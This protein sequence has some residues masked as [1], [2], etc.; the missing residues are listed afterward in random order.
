MVPWYFKSIAAVV[1]II[2]NESRLFMYMI[3]VVL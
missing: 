2:V 3:I 1:R